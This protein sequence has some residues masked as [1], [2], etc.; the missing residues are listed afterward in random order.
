MKIAKCFPTAPWVRGLT[1]LALLIVATAA[2]AAVP[3]DRAGRWGLG[4]EYGFMRLGGGQHGYS[5]IE[6]FGALHVDYAFGPAWNLQL[7]LRKGYVRPTAGSSGD[8]GGEWTTASGAPLYTV[9]NQPSLRLMR[10]F[11]VDSKTSPWVEGGLGLTSWK[12]IDKTGEEVGWFPDGD[13]VTGYDESG[14]QVELKRSEFT[15]TVGAGLDF[16]LS[17]RWDLNLG[18]RLHLMPGV[19]RDNIGL[20]YLWDD[21]KYVDANNLNY[22]AFLGVSFWFGSSDDDGDGIPNRDDACPKAAEDLD[23]YQDQDGCPDPDND[24]DGIPDARDA[25]PDEPEDR[26]GFA[27]EDGCPDPDN[28]GDGV[29]DGQDECPNEAEDLDGYQDEDGC[30]DPD[31]DGDGVPD[32]QDLCPDTPAEALVDS[33]GC[34]TA[35]MAAPAPSVPMAALPVPGQTMVIAGVAFTTGSARLTPASKSALDNL[36]RAILAHP[37]AVV[38]IRGHTDD[39]GDAE[40]NR[41]LSARRATA[42]RDALVRR[43][44]P[45][46]RV[47]AVGYGEDVPRAPNNS[48][49]GRGVNRRVELHRI[50]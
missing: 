2:M 29:P 31:N 18:A 33:V 32:D 36:A 6:Q 4:L 50:Q 10:R 22:E 11:A 28:D 46:G 44:V 42:V 7:A 34:E 17:D 37:D 20:S 8:P 49:E 41:E 47:R 9:M 5:N 14:N 1:V 13:P 23:G 27:D 39:V 48:P 35:A 3:A 30:P 12:V 16:V 45:P 40:A 24:G 25:C 21:V 38:E 43:G 26:D 15:L 19:D